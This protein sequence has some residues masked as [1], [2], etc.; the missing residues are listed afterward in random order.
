LVTRLPAKR[1]QIFITNSRF[2]YPLSIVISAGADDGSQALLAA[3]NNTFR[4]VGG[5]SRGIGLVS[6]GDGQYYGNR[7]QLTGADDFA[8]VVAARCQAADNRHS[9]PRCQLE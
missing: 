5:Q 9:S 1:S 3:K 7:F 8:Y 6:T 4:S 2:D